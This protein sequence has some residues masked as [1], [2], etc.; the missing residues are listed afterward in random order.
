M[1]FHGV[2][3]GFFLTSYV[4]PLRSEQRVGLHKSDD[5]FSCLSFQGIWIDGAFSVGAVFG[6]KP[7]AAQ[8]LDAQR[9]TT[10]AYMHTFALQKAPPPLLDGSF[11]F[12]WRLKM[13]AFSQSA[14]TKSANQSNDTA[15]NAFHNS[16]AVDCANWGDLLFFF[17]VRFMCIIISARNPERQWMCVGRK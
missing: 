2:Q 16:N 7:L 17:G 1:P 6:T 13:L 15:L 8:T 12:V 9:L 14:G 3:C 5:R 10:C 11:G 4:F